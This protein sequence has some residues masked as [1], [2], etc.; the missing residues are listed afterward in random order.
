MA[1]DE[2]S[3]VGEKGRIS[4]DALMVVARALI[5]MN[6]TLLFLFVHAASSIL[7]IYFSFCIFLAA[8][9]MWFKVDGF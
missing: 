5:D 6:V 1:W 2:F 3:V 7:M 8:G 9:W 4:S